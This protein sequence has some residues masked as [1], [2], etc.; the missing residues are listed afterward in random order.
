M[1]KEKKRKKRKEKGT[2][3][4]RSQSRLD[5][6]IYFLPTT[7]HH[8]LPSHSTCSAP[9]PTVTF[10]LLCITSCCHWYSTCSEPLSTV[11][12]NLICTINTVTFNLIWTTFNRYVQPDLHHLIPSRSTWSGPLNTVTFNLLWT[13]SYC[14]VQSVTDS[15][16]PSRSTCSS[17][18]PIPPLLWTTSYTHVQL[19]SEQFLT[20][21]STCYGP[22]PT[23]QFWGHFL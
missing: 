18:R 15:F 23:D 10:D 17:Y 11:T 19:A 2:F 3:P 16:L 8:F 1:K 21:R 7:L 14:H 4:T 12:F 13:S 22:H 9:L 5:L 20:S 6:S